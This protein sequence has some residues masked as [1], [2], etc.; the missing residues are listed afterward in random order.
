MSAFSQIVK[1]GCRAGSALTL[2]A[3]AAALSAHAQTPAAISV[4][5]SSVTVRLSIDGTSDSNP[6]LFGTSTQ[7]VSCPATGIVAKVSSTTDG[8]AKVLVDNY[9]DLTLTQGG[10]TTGPTNIC[11]G[12]VS[13]SGYN[14]CF[15]TGYQS[16]AGAGQLTGD[17][18][19]GAITAAGGVG[20]IDIS[21]LLV[22]GANT[23]RFDEVDTGGYLAASSI[24]LY[25]NCS[26]EG[27]GGTGTV[28]GTPISSTNPTPAELTQNFTF[29]GS[30]GLAVG[31]EFDLSNANNAGTLDI[32]DQAT[33]TVVDAALDPALFPSYVAGTSFATSQCLIHLGEIFDGSPACKLYTLTCQIG[34]GSEASGVQCPTS[35]ARNIVVQDIFDFPALTL[36]DIKVPAVGGGVETFH[37]G[38]GLLEASEGWAGGPCTF[39]PAAGQYYSCPENLLTLFQGPGLGKG[40]GTPSPSVNSTFISV[41]PVPEICTYNNIVG[42]GDDEWIN[43]RT[44]KIAFSAHPPKVPAPNNGFVAA[45]VYGITYGVSPANAVPSTEFPVPGDTTLL[46]PD[47]CPGTLP[48][49][50]FTPAPATV[51]VP[52]DGQYLVHYFATDCAGT[53]ELYFYQ[54]P[55]GSWNTKFMTIPLNVDT[56]PPQIVA[57]PTLSPTP[58]L[59]NG[60][61]GYCKNQQVKATFTCTDD[62]SGVKWCG[63]QKYSN[64]VLAPPPHSVAMDTSTVGSHTFYARTQ[65]T[66]QNEGTAV[67][68]S[69]N[70]VACHP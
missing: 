21:A 22:P 12:G 67:P 51:S 8:T 68:V 1:S 24:Y 49:K 60:V 5:P 70:V 44:V 35:T 57:G 61:L 66:A 47:G 54:D 38:F 30:T 2:L 10:T 17:D 31:F 45:P 62:R 40:T 16:P 29:S 6:N 39:D 36:P 11:S 7:N 19:N 69:Y 18:P 3:A 53:E 42:F 20:P 55:T 63:G 50:I 64:P 32:T 46:D 41:G 15:T 59:I 14:D 43:N 56:V 23:L 4:F 37:Q 65:D 28:T 52:S 34:Q 27:A 48:A 25:T 58:T 9:I 33:P 26:A 13:E